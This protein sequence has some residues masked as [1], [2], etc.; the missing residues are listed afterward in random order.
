M[1]TG[2]LGEAWSR[3]SFVFNRRRM[4]SFRHL[5]GMLPGHLRLVGGDPGVDP[6]LAGGIINLIW[7][8]NTS[9]SPRR[10]WKVLL[11]R[12]SPGLPSAA[13]NRRIVYV[14]VSELSGVPGC[15]GQQAGHLFC[16]GLDMS[17]C[18]MCLCSR[19]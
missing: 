15:N 14:Q 2:H 11:G 8:G 9:G 18:Q 1:E 4:R 7:P 12:D 3:A 17:A 5:I 19:R 6:E 13:D 10:S 16:S